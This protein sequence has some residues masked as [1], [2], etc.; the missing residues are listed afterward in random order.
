MS[1]FF[2]CTISYIIHTFGFFNTLFGKK[3]HIKDKRK[4]FQIDF[5]LLKYQLMLKLHCIK[6][7]LPNTFVIVSQ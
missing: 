6:N 5:I 4:T 3:N 7:V 2:M 1:Y